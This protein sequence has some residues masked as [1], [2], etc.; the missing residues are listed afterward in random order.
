MYREV[1][2]VKPSTPR[3][4]EP[5]KPARNSPLPARPCRYSHRL[6]RQ[7]AKADAGPAPLHRR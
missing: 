2:P 3:T 4:I 7:W 5:K 6:R 1:A